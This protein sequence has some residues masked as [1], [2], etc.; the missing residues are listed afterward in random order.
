[1]EDIVEDNPNSRYVDYSCATNFEHF[2]NDIEKA[3]KS[4]ELL[5]S[6]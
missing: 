2:I 5:P 4:W 1:M 3:L 6:F